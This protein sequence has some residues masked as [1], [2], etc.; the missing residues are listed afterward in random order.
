[1]SFIHTAV[2][3][4]GNKI[5]SVLFSEC[6]T[7]FLTI[8]VEKLHSVLCELVLR[9]RKIAVFRLQ[10]LIMN[11][12]SSRRKPELQ[13]VGGLNSCADTKSTCCQTHFEVAPHFLLVFFL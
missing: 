11:H 13:I 6:C 7:F 4:T 10:L 9:Q 1:M 8:T 3:I 5:V 12:K 2:L